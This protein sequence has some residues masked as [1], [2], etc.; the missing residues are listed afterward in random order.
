VRQLFASYGRLIRNRRYF[1]LWLGQLTSNL[2]D[3]SHYI[4]LVIWVYQRTGSSLVVAGTVFFEVVPVLLLA[5]VAG[6]VIPINIRK[7][8][9][10]RQVAEHITPYDRPSSSVFFASSII[11]LELKETIMKVLMFV[12]G[13]S[14]LTLIVACGQPPAV[15]T[16]HGGPVRDHVGLVDN[17]RA[18]GYT[19]E[20]VGE[21]Q[22]PFLR[23]PGTILRVSGG[24]LQQP[25][26][27]QSYDYDDAEAAA[28]DAGQIQPDGS[29]PTTMITWVE[30][31]HFFRQERAFVIYVGSN[32]T[33]LDVLAELMGPQFAGQ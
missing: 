15:D 4:A 25:V 13:L 17:L 7:D 22:Q 16:S 10:Q 24:N 11:T 1:P 27:I 30:P 8:R 9:E 32:P 5:P 20:P 2:G 21:V 6:V 28:A 12:L 14:I 23:A 18:K 26:E 31:P 33:M 29:T 19:V 3:T